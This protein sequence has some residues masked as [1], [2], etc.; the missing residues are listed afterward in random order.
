MNLEWNGHSVNGSKGSCAL[1]KYLGPT[2]YKGS[3]W[4]ATVSRDSETMWSAIASYDDGPIVA[5]ENLIEKYGLDWE[6]RGCAHVGGIDSTYAVW[7]GYRNND[8]LGGS[9]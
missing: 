9:K 3:R 1:V 7:F 5:V 8:E 4:K 2:D 6:V